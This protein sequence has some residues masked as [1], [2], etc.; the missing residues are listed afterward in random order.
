MKVVGGVEGENGEMPNAACLYSG[1][2]CSVTRDEPFVRNGIMRLA[3]E[4][5]GP[6]TPLCLCQ[7]RSVIPH[8]SAHHK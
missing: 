3:D 6:E 8:M 7:T 1:K 5:V 2:K 4:V